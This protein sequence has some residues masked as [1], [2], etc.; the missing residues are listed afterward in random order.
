MVAQPVGGG[1]G[2]DMREVEA[3]IQGVVRQVVGALERVDDLS[4]AKQLIDRLADY[5]HDELGQ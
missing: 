3:V 5:C 4:E 1:G 2:M